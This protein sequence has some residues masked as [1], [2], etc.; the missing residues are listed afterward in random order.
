MPR[1]VAIIMDGNGR[2]AQKRQ[3]PRIAGHRAGVE[4]VRQIVQT[5]GENGIGIL[6][7]FAF[8]SE[9]WR[10]PKREV[11]LLMDLFLSALQ[12]EIEELDDKNVRLRVLGDRRAFPESLQQSIRDAEKLTACNEGLHLFIAANYGGR[13]DITQAVKRLAQEA[14]SGS[15]DPAEIDSE[16]IGSRLS[17]HGV[18][19]PDLFIRTGGEQRISNFLLWHLAYTELYFTECL[20][21]EFDRDEFAKALASFAR[22]QRR[23]GQTAEQVQQLSRA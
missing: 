3:L 10:R 18:P 16:L 5:C 6:T 19:E 20:W 9:N 21:P 2:W 13:W 8:S 1:H 15:L 17:L 22:R 7:L 14:A 23:F 12:Q 11:S 4:T